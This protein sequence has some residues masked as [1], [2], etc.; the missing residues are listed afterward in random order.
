MA[1]DFRSFR[2]L[3]K[4]SSNIAIVTHWNPD[5]DAVGSSLGLF[6]FLRNYGKNP[7]VIVPNSFP[8]FL[9]W[10]PGIERV[11]NFQEEEEKTKKI[12]DTADIIFTLD[13]NSFK[14]LDQ[15]GPYLKNT[16]APKVLI[17]HHPLPED[18]AFFSFHD[19]KACSTSELIFRL[20]VKL[21]SKKMLDKKAAA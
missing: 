3:L 6:H 7:Q 5:G 15:L 2:N 10:L 18:Y 1:S 17:D 14:R 11:I 16:T 9:Q 21:R 13:F 20:I 19:D 4:K 12:L 8:D